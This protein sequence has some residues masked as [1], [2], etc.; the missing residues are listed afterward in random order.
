MDGTI[1]RTVSPRPDLHV[2]RLQI[3]QAAFLHGV[4]AALVG[5]DSPAAVPRVAFYGVATPETDAYL[6]GFTQGLYYVDPRIRPLVRLFPINHTT[7]V[8]NRLAANPAANTTLAAIRTAAAADFA[9]VPIIYS[10]LGAYTQAVFLAAFDAGVL[11]QL[12]TFVISDAYCHRAPIRVRREGSQDPTGPRL[13]ADPSDVLLSTVVLRLGAVV[14]GLLQR[15]AQSAFSPPAG[16]LGL[17]DGVVDV[18][19]DPPGNATGVVTG[20]KARRCGDST[21]FGMV[22]KVR[23]SMLQ[24]QVSVPLRVCNASKGPCQPSSKPHRCSAA[25]QPGQPVR[26]MGVAVFINHLQAVDIKA[27]NF[28]ADFNLYLYQAKEQYASLAQLKQSY[29]DL[30][31]DECNMKI[32][33]FEAFALNS[34]EYQVNFL[35]MEASRTLEQLS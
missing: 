32:G 15:G 31:R 33:E 30:Q 25:A 21:V 3:E 11:Q 16:T 28:Y 22:Q 34:P 7:T 20:W 1:S 24:S 9:S 14:R 6:V 17:G 12:T 19:W 8:Y 27:G 23:A 5:D 13:L 4:I 18:V 29:T 26:K 2:V 10:A 35:N